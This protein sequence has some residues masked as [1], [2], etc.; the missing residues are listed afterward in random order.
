MV[1]HLRRGA[2]AGA[3]GRHDSPLFLGFDAS[4]GKSRGAQGGFAAIVPHFSW[5]LAVLW[6]SFGAH[7]AILRPKFPTIQSSP[8]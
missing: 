3:S 2:Q 5:D 6:G 1:R 8:N 4:V 7:K